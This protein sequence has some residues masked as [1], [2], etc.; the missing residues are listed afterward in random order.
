MKARQIVKNHAGLIERGDRSVRR[1]V[2][3]VLEAT[4]DALDCCRIIKKNL[5]VTGDM[6][7]F[8]SSRWDLSKK[9]RIYVVGG[10]KAANSMARAIEVILADRITT[11]VV[12]VK[13]LESGD[14]LQRIE[15]VAAKCQEGDQ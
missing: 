5:A 1:P 3:A 8:G 10:G 2:L 7:T 14:R 15:L 11:G 13:N 4:L 9:R 6:M 12:A